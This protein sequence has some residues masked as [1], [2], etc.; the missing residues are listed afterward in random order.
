MSKKVKYL[1]GGYIGV[2]NDKVAA[3][4]EKKGVVKVLGDAS[5]PTKDDEK[6]SDEK[7]D[8]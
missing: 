2:A 3:I 5:K 8:K 6:K 7:A 1:D 4:L